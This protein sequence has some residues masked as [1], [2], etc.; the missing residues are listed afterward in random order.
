M[1]KVPFST[2]FCRWIAFVC[3]LGVGAVCARAGGGEVYC[4]GRGDSGQL[5]VGM[6]WRDKDSVTAG[7]LGCPAPVKVRP[8]ISRDV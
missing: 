5:G 8:L 4:W 2:Y 7:V 1:H 6:R 3:L